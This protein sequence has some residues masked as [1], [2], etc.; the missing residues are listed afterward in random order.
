MAV[1][2]DPRDQQLDGVE[3]G[4]AELGEFVVDAGWDDGEHQSR[5]KLIRVSSWRKVRVSIRWLIQYDVAA[6][7]AEP[8][9]AIGEDADHE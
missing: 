6:Q 8:V 9:H 3:Q 7:F 2:A 4:G 5:S 1:F